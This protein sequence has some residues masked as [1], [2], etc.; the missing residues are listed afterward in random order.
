MLWLEMNKSFHLLLLVGEER[1]LPALTLLNGLK[2]APLGLAGSSGVTGVGEDG[3]SGVTGV[4]EDGGDLSYSSSE[5]EKSSCSS[6]R[7]SS[8][9]QSSTRKPSRDAFVLSTG[10]PFASLAVLVPAP[11]DGM[12]AGEGGRSALG[13]W[14]IEPS[15]VPRADFSPRTS[16]PPWFV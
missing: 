1:D 14:E 12:T 13:I 5:Q 11:L 2:M 3:S 15:S 9:E 8:S 16:E 4:N 10:D 6:S 7:S